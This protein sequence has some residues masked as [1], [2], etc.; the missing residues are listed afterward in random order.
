M[1]P[2]SL[3]C[4]GMALKSKRIDLFAKWKGDKYDI[5]LLQDTHWTEHTLLQAKEE[6]D[7]KIISSTYSSNSRG[8]SILINNSF[9]FTTAKTIKDESGNYVI[10]ELM[11]PDHMNPIVCSIYGPN[12]DNEKF[13]QKLDNDLKSFANENILIGGDWNATRN[14]ELDNKNYITQNNIKNTKAITLLIKKH[15][16]TDIWRQENANKKRFTW[17]QGLSCKQARLDYFLCNEELASVCSNED[18]LYKYRSDHAP[19]TITISINDQPRGRGSWKLNNSLL[20]EEKFVKLIKKEI[21]NFKLAHCATPYNHDYVYP[22][23]AEIE[24]MVDPTLFWESLMATLRGTIITYSIKNGKNKKNKTKGLEKKIASLDFRVSS[25]IASIADLTELK[26]LNTQLIELRQEELNGAFIRS[27]A[28]WHELGEKPSK[29]FLNLENKNKINK[30]ISEIKLDDNR[31]INDQHKILNELKNFYQNLYSKKEFFYDEDYIPTLNLTTLHET[32]KSDLEKD[33]TIKELDEALKALKNNK[34]PGLDGFSPEFFKKFWPELKH[35]F[36]QYVNDSHN[37]GT[38]TNS[39]LEGI[40]TCLP[41]TGKE[42]NLIKNW[43]PISLL[44]T[45]YKLI[46]TCITNRLRPLL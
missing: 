20:K 35:Y 23:N 16:L 4:R 46:S 38:L 21:L 32:E 37:K 44:N 13:Y 45:T 24:F 39:L 11:L 31:I 30:T 22:R 10:T 7:N 15:N 27:R 6:W 18:I 3:N 26:D 33:I 19:I 17:L 5:I 34:A 14:F 42:R 36:L 12:N 8:T 25:G 28:E 1:V 29:F 43:R 2:V 9:E 41:K 40:I